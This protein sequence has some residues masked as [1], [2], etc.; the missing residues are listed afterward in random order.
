[1]KKK[2]SILILLP[3]L[4]L[5]LILAIGCPDDTP[6]ISAD[7]VG[8][9]GTPV[10]GATLTANLTPAEAVAT[11]QWMQS[12]TANGTYTNISGSTA[13]NYLL[14]EGDIGKFIKVKA[15]SGSGES[16]KTLTSGATPIAI[17]RVFNSTKVKGYGAIQEA[18]SAASEN[19]TILVGSG[20]YT[21][22]ISLSVKGLTL[23][24]ANGR[25]KTTIDGD[26]AG[27]AVQVSSSGLG[28]ITFD[29]FTVKGW[30]NGGI[31]QP[32][33]SGGANSAFKVLNNKVI[34]PVDELIHGN[35]IQVSGNG[36]LVKSNEVEAA[37]HIG[38]D[39]HA[40]GILV[41]NAEDVTVE[42]NELYGTEVAIS[43]QGGKYGSPTRPAKNVTIKNNTIND[44]DTAITVEYDSSN[45]TITGNTISDVTTGLR[46]EEEGAL[47]PD[48]NLNT[49]LTSNTFPAGFAVDAGNKKIALPGDPD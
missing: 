45:L 39:Y 27:Y 33:G 35:S 2:W 5:T 8:I 43:V 20:T 49:V 23:K 38:L 46:V 13:K 14:K 11:Y 47:I 34:A 7:S 32:M 24:S 44:I 9:Q 6:A 22:A 25:E 3:V 17:A 4:V 10:I 15:T 26:G 12:D 36:S 19:D 41:V 29:G 28:P 40:T 1:M 21:G 37:A 18:I 30:K 48:I 16:A 42:E 31:N